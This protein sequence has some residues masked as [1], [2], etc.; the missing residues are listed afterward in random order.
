MAQKLLAFLLRQRASNSKQGRVR[1][2][3]FNE[4][5]K[6]SR[7]QKPT[8][9][10]ETVKLKVNSAPNQCDYCGNTPNVLYVFGSNDTQLREF[11]LCLACR[12]FILGRMYSLIA[13]KKA[14]DRKLLTSTERT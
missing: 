14:I 10:T 13:N 4:V 3:I 2:T 1:P 11:S 12:N 9:M 7:K 5:K 8:W 6:M